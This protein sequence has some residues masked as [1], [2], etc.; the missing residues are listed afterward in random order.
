M[1]GAQVSRSIVSDPPEDPIRAELYGLDHRIR[2]VNTG[3]YPPGLMGY[4]R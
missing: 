3:C 1:R 2:S 4:G